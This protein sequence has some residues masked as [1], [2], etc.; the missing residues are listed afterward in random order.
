MLEFTD[1]FNLHSIRLDVNM[2]ACHEGYHASWASP[3]RCEASRVWRTEIP[4]FAG[5]Q[6]LGRL[7]I[8]GQRD[9]SSACEV[10]DRLMDF[11][12][13][14]ECRLSEIV[15]EQVAVSRANAASG[16]GP[17]AALAPIA[18][19]APL[20]PPLGEGPRSAAPAG[21]MGPSEDWAASKPTSKL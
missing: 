3:I 18:T 5:E 14:F 12:Y 19:P 10:I 15:S 9:H 8:T 13:P 4:L 2:P 20:V 1:K 7:T 17:L 21:A 6:V 16:S 11:L